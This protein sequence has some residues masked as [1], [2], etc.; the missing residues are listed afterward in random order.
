[1][2]DTFVEYL[3]SKPGLDCVMVAWKKQYEKLGHL[4][5]RIVLHNPSEETK[6]TLTTLLSK[7]YTYETTI[8]VSYTF[9]CKQLQQTKFSNCDFQ[10]VLFSYFDTVLISKKQKRQEQLSL[11]EQGFITLENRYQNTSIVSYITYLCS[12]SNLTGKIKNYIKTNTLDSLFP[13]LDA[14]C[15][16][17]SFHHTN[18]LIS[19]FA[20]K[21]LQ[22]PHA[23]DEGR[24]PYTFL[25]DCLCFLEHIQKENMTLLEKNALFTKYGLIKDD[26]STHTMICHLLGM[27]HSTIH[28]GWL[29]FYNAYEPMVIT[30]DNL[31]Q[32]DTIT[33]LDKI[34]IIE[35]PSI[36]RILSMTIK[37]SKQNIGLICTSGQLN[38][39][40]Y[41][42]LN[43]CKNHCLYYAGD[44]DPEGLLIAQKL[45]DMLPNLHL[46][47]YDDSDY[48]TSI[49]HEIITETRLKKL[50]HI[51]Q[52]QLKSIAAKLLQTKK[53][54]YQEN[55][56][57]TYLQ[58]LMF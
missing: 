33:Q 22:N 32:I 4:G 39:A 35:N 14:L 53:A 24:E 17:P 15:H 7:D 44:F 54:G 41:S 5:G 50:N 1:M 40:D 56:L 23:F 9:W 8:T 6:Q 3:K 58:D 26:L 48:Y 16:I 37:Q 42:I 10:D 21:Y 38:S 49:S 2:I 29:G 51:T 30:M 11:L 20:S 45:I 27:H 36:F 31:S 25:Y 28:P 57:E 34:Y 43:I 12:N 18:S 19:V 46:W 13:I 52:P 55:L 47:H